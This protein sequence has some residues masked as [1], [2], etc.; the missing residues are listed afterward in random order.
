M[1]INHYALSPDFWDCEC[2]KDY[3]HS[4]KTLHCSRCGTTEE[5]QPDSRVNEVSKFHCRVYIGEFLLKI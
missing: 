4:R 3:I 1:S 2:E 5:E